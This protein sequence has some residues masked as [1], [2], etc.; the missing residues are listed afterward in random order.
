M[1]RGMD[2]EKANAMWR[3]CLNPK[4]ASKD[5]TT[6]IFFNTS[7]SNVN[8]AVGR[9]NHVEDVTRSAAIAD[10]FCRPPSPPRREE[11]EHDAP[12]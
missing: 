11:N 12:E 9:P 3:I 6:N 7:A 10:L 2:I 8:W 4:N 1:G 5:D